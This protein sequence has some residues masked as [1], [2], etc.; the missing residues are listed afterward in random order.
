MGINLALALK[1]LQQNKLQTILTLLGVSVGVAMVVIVS[2]L[3]LGA[4][5]R[6][7]SQIEGAGPT[8]IE[9][10]AG[11]Y[12]PPA[13]AGDVTQDS[14]GGEPSQGMAV[15]GFGNDGLG[16]PAVAAAMRAER[17]RMRD[18][19]RPMHHR[20]PASPLSKADLEA[21]RT[22]IADTRAVAGRVEGNVRLGETAATRLRTVRAS[23][24]EAPWPD[25]RGWKVTAGRLIS[26]REHADGA[27][28]MVATAEV[29]ARLFPGV[30]TPVGQ[31]LDVAGRDVSLVGIV[32]DT[33]DE[34]GALIPMIHVP[35]AAA[36][37]MLGQEALDSISV[38]TASV[39]VTTQVSE[40]VRQELRTLHGLAEDELDDFRVKTQSVAALPSLGANPMLARSVHGNVVGLEAE[41][42]A[43]MAKS[44]RAAGR[45]FTLLL[46]G[47]AGVSLLVGGIGVMN[48]MLVSV[49]SRTRE[50]GLRMALGARAEDVMVQFLVEAVALAALG[51]LM[52]LVLGGIGLL[53]ADYG[54][55]WATAV[56]P[57][58][59]VL[60]VVVAGVTGI[61]FGIGPARRAAALDPVIALKAE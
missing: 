4:Q 33:K 50:I 41:S 21:L 10:R 5:E 23:G 3:G 56:S 28:V 35:L 51:G 34:A 26:E 37:A 30:A 38:R 36:Q 9:I 6:I 60:A 25:M 55:H 8:M 42:W 19:E 53:V 46:A 15:M 32:S 20:T 22:R 48:I 49:S 17:Q 31:S 47:A 29:V 54:L 40:A 16:D 1:A 43:E 58:M 45:T 24:I 44:L 61:A 52:G 39:A 7:E 13:I 59:I 2:G 12:Q 14:S 11:N 57:F 18:A 27:P